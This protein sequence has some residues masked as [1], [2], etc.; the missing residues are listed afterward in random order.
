MEAFRGRL[1]IRCFKL[2]SIL[3]VTLIFAIGG[4]VS[5]FAAAPS[6]TVAPTFVGVPGD[7]PNC[8]GYVP[9]VTC[10]LTITKTLDTRSA[11]PW[12][13]GSDTVAKF[14]PSSGILKAGESQRVLVVTSACG[15]YFHFFFHFPGGVVTVTYL[16]G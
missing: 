1:R 8:S 7:G 13:S 5:A 9:P 12:S 6:L 14:I 15:G 10:Q 16:C 2:L 11:L 4:S 3:A